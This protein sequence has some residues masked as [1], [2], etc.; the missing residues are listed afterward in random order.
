MFHAIKREIN[1][2]SAVCNGA[3]GVDGSPIRAYW[4]ECNLR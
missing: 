3:I 2:I 1:G 4:Q